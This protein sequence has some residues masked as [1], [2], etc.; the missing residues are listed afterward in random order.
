MVG[1][2][3]VA[4]TLILAALVA[5]C[6]HG[7]ASTPPGTRIANPAELEQVVAGIDGP[8]HSTTTGYSPDARRILD[9]V[10]IQGALVRYNADKGQFPRQLDDL[11][12]AYAPQPENGS[13]IPSDPSG[14][15]YSY[16]QS[17]GGR[18][19]TLSATLS[20]GRQFAGLATP[21]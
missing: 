13:R 11:L 5:G 16:A 3:A 10:S 20:N 12:P 7:D 6:G 2:V 4:G 1:R 15:P 8:V 17:A 9:I 14:S 19:Y 21:N 18:N